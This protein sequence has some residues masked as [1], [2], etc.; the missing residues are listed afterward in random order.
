MS[1]P[2]ISAALLK[3]VDKAQHE[4]NSST[5]IKYPILINKSIV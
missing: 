2:C 5:A 3:Y 1:T 4:R